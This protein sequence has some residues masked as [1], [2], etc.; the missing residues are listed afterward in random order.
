M[1]IKIGTMLPKHKTEEL[2]GGYNKKQQDWMKTA[3]E[4]FDFDAHAQK[5]FENGTKEVNEK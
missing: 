5:R 4:A 1:P 3:E 2:T